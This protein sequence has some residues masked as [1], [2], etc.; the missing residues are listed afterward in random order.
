MPSSTP[1]PTPS[2]GPA[3]GPSSASR[4]GAPRSAW[5]PDRKIALLY[6][7]YV[8]A[9]VGFHLCAR[10]FEV[11]TGVSVWYPPV[12]LAL[13]L[14]TMTGWR[15]APLVL[16]VNLYSA[17]VQT[18]GPITWTDWV[19]PGLF[20]LIYVGAGGAVHRW[21]GPVPQPTRPAPA[22]ALIGT[23]LAAVAVAAVAGAAVVLAAGYT[24]VERFAVLTFH[25]WMGDLTGMLT[26][27]PLCL[28]HVAPRLFQPAASSPRRWTR[29]QI[30][31]I[32]AQACSLVG[33]LVVVHGFGYLHPHQAYYLSFVP[34]VWICL[35]HGLPGATIAVFALT[36]GSLLSLSF[37]RAP[38]V[39]VTDL[40]LF[41]IALAVIG[42]GLGAT[43]TRR[44]RAETDRSRLL[45][46]LEA[47]PDFVCTAA[48]DGRVLYQNLALQRLRGD[49]PGQPPA[50]R[51]LVDLH[52]PWAAERIT[53]EG[54]PIALAEGAWHGETA[55]R[56]RDGGEIPVLEL[57]LVHRDD[58]GRA[59][60][61]SSVARDISSQ[62]QAE[63]A[64]LESERSLLQA[65]KLDSLRVLAGGIAHDFN[66]LLTVVLGHATMTRLELAADSPAEKAV[67]QIELAALRAADLCRQMLA[68]SGRNQ[69]ATEPLDLTTIVEETGDLLRVSISKKCRL[70]L[71]LSRALPPV[72]GDATQLSQIAMNLVI[73]ASDASE[74]RG[75]LILLRTGLCDADATYLAD[76]CFVQSP[77]PGPYVYLEV[78]DHGCGMSPEVRRRIFEPFFTTKF[79]GH[80]LGLSAV[81]GIVRAHGGGIKVDSAPGRGTTFRVLLPIA[82]GAARPRPDKLAATTAWRGS[83]RALVVDDEESVRE[84]A[85]RMLRHFG[86]EPI[87]AADG[88]EALELFRAAPGAF[89]LVL[90]DLSMPVM[91]GRETFEEIF[92]LDPTTPVL[93]MSGYNKTG[94]PDSFDDPRLSGVVQKPFETATLGRALRDAWDNDLR[95]VA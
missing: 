69:L 91:D 65:Q 22:A 67:H 4:V 80:G 48:L 42:L 93:L 94:A 62:K 28:V 36:M 8:L 95:R 43:V 21:F 60:M 33:A 87:A 17:L 73:N 66:N 61:L 68:Y 10:F 92:R 78:T 74:E 5:R 50:D 29:R 57:I 76:A 30:W 75:G 89:A 55:L 12:G 85:C 38:A 14:A 49:A 11:D 46:I 41:E 58:A 23:Y 47:S 2:G 26:V 71:E 70:Q 32:V 6:V 52:C 45:A 15:C 13:A 83:G 84:I 79:T 72:Q 90:L 3:P 82:A 35:R 63:R 88:R 7:A 81:L 34:L 16:A 51:Q 9:H 1:S 20:T 31:E 18:P 19:L 37:T 64:R 24:P 53:R 59:V 56:L 27:V 39:L 40:V 77:A 54:I 25:W 44:A 86:F